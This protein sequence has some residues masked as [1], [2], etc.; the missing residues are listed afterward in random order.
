[1]R[2]VG[3]TLALAVLGVELASC[4]VDDGQGSVSGTLNIPEC[5]TG[6]FDLK[7]DFFA[8]MAY[9]TSLQGRL[10]QG[11]DFQTFSDGLAFSVADTSKIRPDSA[12]GFAGFYGQPIPVTLPPGVVPPG[13][14]IVATRSPALVSMSVYL[15]RTCRTRNVS[16]YAVDGV[17]LEPD[18]SCGETETTPLRCN[19]DELSR[20]IGRSTVTFSKLPNGVPDERN[21][22]D[23]LVE[24]TFDIYVA[25]AREGC[26]PGTIPPPCRGHLK[27]NF[28]FYYERSKPA[29]PFP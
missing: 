16:L 14:P 11:S 15:Q 12:Q 9:R 6:P 23:R 28:R 4:S 25:D 8:A 3:L 19:G 13:T 29:Q 10:Q 24:G 17:L 26:A 5:W 18:G 22:E 21:A 20:P 1:M 27:G 2:V 7:P